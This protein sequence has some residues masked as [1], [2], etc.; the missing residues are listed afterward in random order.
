[1]LTLPGGPS[2]WNL[3]RGAG[4]GGRGAL[5]SGQRVPGKYLGAELGNHL[6]LIK[7]DRFS[8]PKM[9][10]RESSSGCALAILKAGYHNQ[11]PWLAVLFILLWS[12]RGISL[13]LI[14]QIL[15]CC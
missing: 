6:L 7:L 5:E 4:G 12:L 8:S 13:R 2:G 11:R 15:R 14:K 1:M 3:S 9:L 10:P